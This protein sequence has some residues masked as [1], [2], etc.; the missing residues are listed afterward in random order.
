MKHKLL[1]FTIAALSAIFI[2]L[3]VM[4]AEKE[5]VTVELT[6]RKVVKDANG[7]DKFESAE[8]AKPGDVIEYKAV[9]RNKGKNVAANVLATIPVPLGT[10][11]L[12]GSVKPAGITASL[13]GKEFASVPL[14][15][16]VKL[17]SGKEELRDVPYEEY[18]AIRWEIK[19][20]APG[21]SATVS[22]RVKISTEQP[23]TEAPVK[24]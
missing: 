19:T 7:K 23:K 24:K 1:S 6:N 14:K 8:K 13:D 17:P 5:S 9:Y 16:K 20:L 10:E 3:P 15:R 18:R 4:A 12:P 11:Y 21:K 2:A 22:M